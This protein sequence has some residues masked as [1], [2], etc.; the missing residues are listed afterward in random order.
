MTMTSSVHPLHVAIAG[1][2]LID[3]IVQPNGTYLPCLGGAPFNLS[4]ALSRQ[5]TGV[6]FLNPFSSDVM[7]RALALQLQSD[8]V[9]LA[10]PEPIGLNTS[11]ALVSLNAEGHPSYAFYRDGIA[12]RHINAK[13]LNELCDSQPE[14][15]LV[16]TGGLALDPRD[17]S[18]YVPWLQAQ[19]SAGRRVVIDANLRPSVMPNLA[20]YRAHV[21]SMLQLADLIKVSDED[22]VHLGWTDTDPVVAARELLVQTQAQMVA[23]TL[24]PKGA[25]LLTPTHSLYAKESSPLS[26]VDTVGAGDSFLAGLIAFMQHQGDLASMLDPKISTTIEHEAL[27][28]TLLAKAL[29]HALASASLC[30]QEQGCVPPRWAEVLAWSATHDVINEA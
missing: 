8:G 13:G 17:E 20:Q 24:G 12:D 15:K 6:L 18:V 4:R 14:L 27:L 10:Q 28:K 16:C 26:V 5:D 7:G 30:V 25:W 3:L 22:L 1:E 2:A 23:L 21:L 29:R 11:L 9:V 19:R